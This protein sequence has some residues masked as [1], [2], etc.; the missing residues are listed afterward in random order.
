[1]DF[2]QYLLPD[3]DHLHLDKWDFERLILQ[4]TLT[5]TSTQTIAYCPVCGTS[6]QRV[7]SRYERTLR[8]LSCINYGMTLLLKV[9][10]FFCINA[11]TQ[12]S[13]LTVLALVSVCR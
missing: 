6:T 4:L 11:A 5:V 1:L 3:Q 7:H 9:R 12:V 8:D 2:L 10:K 13:S